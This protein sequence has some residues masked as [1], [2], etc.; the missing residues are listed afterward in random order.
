MSKL[1]ASEE[2][3]K[4]AASKYQTSEAILKRR[5]HMHACCYHQSHLLV[6]EWL[7]D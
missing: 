2:S 4:G 1:A 3:M 5:I 6:P 7:H